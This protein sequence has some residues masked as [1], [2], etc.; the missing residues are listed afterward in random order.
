MN[1]AFFIIK[2]NEALFI[3]KIITSRHQHAYP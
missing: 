3:I 2:I 1:E